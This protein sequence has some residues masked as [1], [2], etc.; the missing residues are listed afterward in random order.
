MVTTK[1][2]DDLVSKLLSEGSTKSH[3]RRIVV[4]RR[5][6]EGK[7]LDYSHPGETIPIPVSIDIIYPIVP[8][9]R[10]RPVGSKNKAKS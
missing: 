9:K 2:Y 5:E 3:A 10:G 8:K 6:R 1:A 7:V 4:Q